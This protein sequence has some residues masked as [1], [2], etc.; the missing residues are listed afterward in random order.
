VKIG[1]VIELRVSCNHEDIPGSYAHF[2][3]IWI[4]KRNLICVQSM[5]PAQT[6]EST[7]KNLI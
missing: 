2:G 6:I 1:L 7:D 5:T 4:P 3:V